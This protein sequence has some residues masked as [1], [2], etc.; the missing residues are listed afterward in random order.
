MREEESEPR[1]CRV[2]APKSIVDFNDT[3]L[4]CS[5]FLLLPNP[6]DNLQISHD[7]TYI[8]VATRGGIPFVLHTHSIREGMTRALAIPQFNDEFKK[9]RQKKESERAKLV[10][11]ALNLNPDE[12]DDY[13]EEDLLKEE[14]TEEETPAAA[15]TESEV[16]DEGKRTFLRGHCDDV[17]DIKFFPSGKVILTSSA[18]MSLKVQFYIE[19]KFF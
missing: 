15:S 5:V 11:R 1:E 4:S 19:C 2:H 16:G 3:M 13:D 9:L 18:D 7:N 12:F 10:E 8:A 6:L 17:C 14:T